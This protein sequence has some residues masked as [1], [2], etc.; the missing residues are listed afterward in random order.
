MASV[1][2]ILL[3]PPSKGLKHRRVYYFTCCKTL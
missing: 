1:Q 3:I 2:H